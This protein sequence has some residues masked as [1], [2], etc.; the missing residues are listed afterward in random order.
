MS[1]WVLP[2]PSGKS[3]DRERSMSMV[4]SMAPAATMT[5]RAR[6]VRRTLASVSM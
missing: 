5:A 6:T 2:S 4:E 1:P 3:S